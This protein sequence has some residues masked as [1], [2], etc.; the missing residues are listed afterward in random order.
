MNSLT[1]MRRC[2]LINRDP[3]NVVEIRAYIEEHVVELAD[4]LGVTPETITSELETVTDDAV[5]A[6]KMLVA[7]KKAE[8][9]QRDLKRDGRAKSAQAAA[10]KLASRA[11][12]D[13]DR[14]QLDLPALLASALTKRADLLV[15]I[16]EDFTVSVPQAI[17]FDLAKVKLRGLSGFV[18]AEGLHIRWKTGGLNLR[19]HVDPH[20]DHIVLGVSP[21]TVA[22]AA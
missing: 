10:E 5:L 16:C 1:A 4:D 6:T 11:T 15:F 20:A 3:E 14:V 17:L 8:A 19:P 2:I 21:K 7:V 13:W 9:S 22:V 18:D 12:W